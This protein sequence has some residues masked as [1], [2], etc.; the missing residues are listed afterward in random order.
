MLRQGL[1]L[2][3]RPSSRWGRPTRQ[4]RAPSTSSW[5]K[6]WPRRWR[7]RP[8]P[9][10]S[11]SCWCRE[12]RGPG[13][14]LIGFREGC[15]GHVDVGPG[16]GRCLAP[17]GPARR[18]RSAWRRHPVGFRTGPGRRGS[19]S[20]GFAGRGA[21]PADGRGVVVTGHRAGGRGHLGAAGCR[22][23]T[24]FRHGGMVEPGPG[25]GV[26]E[27]RGCHRGLRRRARREAADRAAVIVRPGRVGDQGNAAVHARHPGC[28]GSAAVGSDELRLGCGPPGV[29]RGRPR[30]SVS[31]G[32]R[33]GRV[34]WDS[35]RY[36]V[37]C[38]GTPL[39]HRCCQRERR[40]DGS[41][42][43]LR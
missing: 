6:T 28:D 21:A 31:A 24:A 32:R 4:E 34:Q 38:R 22:G 39:L 25:A 27:G 41:S 12:A 37:R 26:A 9:A 18:M 15:P 10:R 36:W 14:D 40:R 5:P 20:S 30:P 8:P 42:H 3:M 13:A 17:T 33:H 19:R 7:R 29:D 35:L 23:A 43:A 11:P 16:L 1:A 2:S